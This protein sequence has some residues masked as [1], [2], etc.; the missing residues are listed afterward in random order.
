[1][2]MAVKYENHI[3][4]EIKSGLN[5]ARACFRMFRLSVSYLKM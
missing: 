1:M 2:G 3:H 5:S 4:E